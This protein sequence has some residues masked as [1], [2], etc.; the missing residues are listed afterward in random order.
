[1]SS[2][3]EDSSVRWR[4]IREVVADCIPRRIAG[5]PLPDE[6]VIDAHSD[7]MPQLAD[8][9]RKLS[10]IEDAGRRARRGDS[11]HDVAPGDPGANPP[12]P[13]QT[14]AIPGYEFIDEIRRGGQG[15]VF[16]ATQTSTGR[17]VAIKVM[18][19]GPFAGASDR[20]RFQREVQVLAALSHPHIVTIHDSGI[21]DDSSYFVMD[22]VAGRSLDEHMTNLR[23][24]SR[25]E[26]GPGRAA[27]GRRTE[28]S[29]RCLE[30]ALD[31]FAG[32][33]EAVN[34][35]HVAGIIH[36]DLKPS[37]VRI[38]E[39][40]EP[41]ILDFGLAKVLDAPAADGDAMTETGQFLGS[42]PW[43]AP[44]QAAGE[45]AKI[46][47]RT[48]VYALGVIVY[49]M[50]TGRFP[51]DVTG[52]MRD[53]LDNILG[54]E[55]VRPSTIGGG[56][57][58]PAIRIDDEIETIVL[59]CL[60]KQR[61]RRYQT[62]GEL[63][64]D[65]RHYLAGEPIEAKRD[66]TA[67][68]LRKQL[69]RHRLPV[70]VAASFMFVIVAAAIALAVQSARIKQ[71]AQSARAIEAFLTDM[72]ASVDPSQLRTYSGFAGDAAALPMAA[73]PFRKDVSVAEMIGLAGQRIPDRFAGQPDLQ[74][75][76]HETIGMTFLSL[77]H[78]SQAEPHLR[79]ALQ[80]RKDTL[81]SE[82]EDTLRSAML[83]GFAIWEARN[84]RSDEA[85]PLVRSAY[86]GMKR[87]FEADDVRT[88][89]CARI[90]ADVLSAQRRFAESDRLF[91]ATAE[92]Q[93]S[94]LGAEHRD[95]LW[96]RNRWSCSRMWQGRCRS[97][98][99]M[100][101]DVYDK[102]L[103]AYGPDDRITIAAELMVANYEGMEGKVNRALK[104]F[105][106]GYD[107]CKRVLGED[108]PYT[109][110]SMR[111]IGQW[112]VGATTREEQL[113]GAA[114]GLERTVGPEH[115]E[116]LL[117]RMHLGRLYR[118]QGRL[119]EAIELFEQCVE[120][121]V[122][123]RGEEHPLTRAFLRPLARSLR[124]AGRHD[125][126]RL[127]A[128]RAVA[129]ARRW[130]SRSDVAPVDLHACAWLMLTCGPSESRDVEAALPLA[131]R[132]VSG[133][134]DNWNETRWGKPAYVLDGLALAYRMNGEPDLAV[135][136]M[137]TALSDLPSESHW[138]TVYE[139]K[140]A[141]YLEEDGDQRS[142]DTV[143]AD[144]V[145]RTPA[146]RGPRKLAR[147]RRM[148]DLAVALFSHGEFAAFGRACTQLNAMRT[149][150]GPRKPEAF[151]WLVDLGRL[152]STE[153]DPVK[154]EKTVR[155]GLGV[156]RE[157][158]PG[159]ERRIAEMQ[160]ILDALSEHAVDV[161]DG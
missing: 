109:W 26:R 84:G 43:A 135:K 143:I 153:A 78:Y 152:L 161:S 142:S 141:V 36:R 59:K 94:L 137:G 27:V 67:Y 55:P 49:R 28:P 76:A 80:L 130:A 53:V 52:N 98:S 101:R 93:A 150:P 133:I 117:T 158:L 70:A 144:L 4:R 39:N 69:R 66:S 83:L 42:L 154:A 44:E 29:R 110:L 115:K 21:S 12:D 102:S 128:D 32:I 15:R 146:K 71:E 96:T 46:D 54:A 74:A 3:G 156:L 127:L 14:G 72:L 47:T 5:E 87:R 120:V 25:S 50:L 2:V 108:H 123:T 30:A 73:R 106:S 10:L 89:T 24:A 82:H 38:D 88:L 136:T 58:R 118:R 147:V 138:R 100:V 113:A 107:R 41:H 126:A 11:R 122:R 63:A 131:Q 104:R 159:D 157:V 60:A 62:A 119:D 16:R 95:T 112:A 34:S 57:G 56:N 79:K 1:M 85:E 116:T 40:G 9:L 149:G 68:V 139:I 75:I 17:E 6:A 114:A 145:E 51:Y 31:L 140:L 92:V 160:S 81:P 132:A 61:E 20:A 7:L 45:P 48:D 124:L 129:S 134:G 86:L 64:R 23:E 105:R 155:A 97:A 91:A 13:L 99:A 148:A 65:I 125:E 90:L 18:R 33:C 151:D 8:E 77:W 35:A 121:C 103:A 111:W 22:Y 37:N 19:G